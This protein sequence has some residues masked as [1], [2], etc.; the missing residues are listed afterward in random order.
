MQPVARLGWIPS[1]DAGT[2][3]TLERMAA[4]AMAGASDPTVRRMAREIVAEDRDP[5]AALREWMAQRVVFRRDPSG[6]ELLHSP[7]L[8]LQAIQV[9]G[10]VRV[11]CDDAA[12]L[13]AA[14]ALSLGYTVRWVV[15]ALDGR[16]SFQHVWAEVQDREGKWR[17]LDVTRKSQSLG[18]RVTRQWTGHF[19]FRLE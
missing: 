4:L 1:G 9:Q 10:S 12:I 16:K 17:E 18:N 11:D 15:V 13:G 7:V 5:I 3:V 8:M 19:P 2:R 6:V 14:L